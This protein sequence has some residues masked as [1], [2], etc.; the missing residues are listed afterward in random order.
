MSASDVFE[1]LRP[2]TVPLE[3][4]IAD[5][6]WDKL[7][8]EHPQLESG[9][10]ERRAS[11][12]TRGAGLTPAGGVPTNLGGVGRRRFAVVGAAAAAIVGSLAVGLVYSRDDGY[13]VPGSIPAQRPSS[14]TAASPPS[15]P[16]A[17]SVLPTA[18]GVD[19]TET[20][21]VSSSVVEEPASAELATA[22]GFILPAVV[23]EGYEITGL[24]A[25]RSGDLFGSTRWARVDETGAVVG[26]L[27]VRPPRPAAAGDD[28]FEADETLRGVPVDLFS[29]GERHQGAYWIESGLIMSASVTDL[30]RDDL[31]A[32]VE[33]LVVDTTTR[34]VSLPDN[35]L[36]LGLTPESA[37]GFVGD[38]VVVADVQLDPIGAP[39]VGTLT[40]SSSPNTF[41]R[42]LE[43]LVDDD[44]GWEVRTVGDAQMLVKTLSAA[45]GG[46]TEVAWISGDF[47]MRARGAVDSEEVLAFVA[48]LRFVDAA[49]FAAAGAQ[50]TEAMIEW[51]LLDQVTF[52]DGI[53]VSVRSRTD[54]SGANAICVEAPIRQCRE[55]VSEGGLVDGYEDNVFDAFDVAGRTIVIGWQSASEAAR[56]GTPTLRAGDASDLTDGLSLESSASLDQFGS[57]SNG[58]FLKITVPEGERPPALDFQSG[59][60]VLMGVQPIPPEPYVF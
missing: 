54:G 49:S 52:D 16:D 2:E 60:N 14:S 55:Q 44:P 53:V 47:V 12:G 45:Q 18:T 17:S 46:W 1:L 19:L 31:V 15:S 56:L 43:Q 25:G 22:T 50:L 11:T 30:S 8:A 57:T 20:S 35:A 21:V 38:N 4:E 40:A 3:P 29:N 59:E 9:R 24:S 23:P 37:L 7:V 5:R 26:L 32:A 33:S 34:T 28:E 39:R 41:G 51:D 6:V 58:R 42:S 27:S 13:V 36:S 10:S 48:G